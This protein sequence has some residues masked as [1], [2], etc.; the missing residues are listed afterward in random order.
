MVQRNSRESL[1]NLKKRLT[2]TITAAEAEGLAFDYIVLSLLDCA[3]TILTS[4]MGLETAGDLFD[5]LVNAWG[6]LAMESTEIIDSQI[7]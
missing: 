2:D 6:K 7:G 5:D 3:E 1:L 4:S